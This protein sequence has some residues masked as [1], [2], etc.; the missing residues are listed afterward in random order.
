MIGQSKNLKIKKMKKSGKITGL[1]LML[2]MAGTLTLTAQRGMQGGNNFQRPGRDAGVRQGREAVKGDSA[3]VHGQGRG[4]AMGPGN[5]MGGM[6]G[7][8]FGPGMAPGM[9]GNMR[10]GMR[11]EMSPGFRQGG[12]LIPNLTEKQI[13]DIEALRVKQQEEM[14]RFREE[15][16]KKIQTMRDENHKKFLEL[17][18]DD[19]KKA[20]EAAAPKQLPAKATT[21]AATTAP[22][23]K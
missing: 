15:N 7:H 2:V 22:V 20:L 23:K 19:Q 21:P 1:V 13:K 5:M 11:G 9:R 8:G 3:F 14:T 17:L 16:Q 6:P 4:F 18:T 10:G 12:A